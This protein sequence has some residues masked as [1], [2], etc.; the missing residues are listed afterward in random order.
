MKIAYIVPFVPRQV[1]VRS[2]NLIPRLARRHQIHL[3][4]VSSE[5]PSEAQRRYLDQHCESVAYISHSRRRAIW[6][7][8]AALPTKVPMRIAYCESKIASKAVEDL[9]HEVEPDAIYVERWRALQYVPRDAAAPVVCD[10]TDSMTLYNRR[11]KGAGAW[12][13]RIVGWEEH[14]RFSRYEGTLAQRADVCVFCS[15]RDMECVKEQ[16][17]EARYELIPNGVD[18]E[19]YFFKEAG[20]EDPATVVFTGNLKYRPNVHAAEL[21]LAKIFPLIRRQVPE[22]KFVAVGNGAEKALERYRGTGGFET[23]GFVPEL[24]PYLA[25]AT[26]AVAPLTVGSGVSNKLGEGFA[27]GTAVVATPLAC[28]DLPVKDGEHLLIAQDAPQFADRVIA[29]L[30]DA[31]LRRAMAA[32]ARRFVQE[33]YDWESVSRKME[34]VM[35]DVV[36]PAASERSERV[37]ATA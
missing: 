18:C 4:C 35:R 24:R 23:V 9:L 20:E 12:W 34:D 33:Q 36:G 17:P 22:A 29:L 28:G 5:A 8:T 26:V 10:P 27:V 32:R 15:R 1:K 2:F 37:R 3:V 6:Q 13:E 19:K 14:R 30:A 16:A 11:L 7:C 31:R 21:F 25:K